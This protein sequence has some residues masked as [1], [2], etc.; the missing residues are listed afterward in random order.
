MDSC[1]TAAIA[2]ERTRN[3]LSVTCEK[4]CRARLRA[5]EQLA[6]L[7]QVS[8]RLVAISTKG[9]WRIF[10]HCQNIP[11]ATNLS[12]QKSTAISLDAHCLHRRQLGGNHQARRIY[13][14]LWLEDSSSSRLP[15]G[16]RLSAKSRW[17]M[18]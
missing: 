1:V 12:A 8:K 15:S 14:G 13:I 5:F 3:W 16:Y 11:I 9:N 18:T 17:G 10:T 6:D 7:F 4:H 2:R